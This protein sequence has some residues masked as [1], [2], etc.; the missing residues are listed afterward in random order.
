MTSR[1]EMLERARAGWLVHIEWH[2]SPL[3]VRHE[4][5]AGIYLVMPG[6]RGSIVQVGKQMSGVFVL[7]RESL[8]DKQILA[9][10]EGALLVEIEIDGPWR[11]L[12]LPTEGLMHERVD[13]AVR[14]FLNKDRTLLVTDTSERALTA[15][16]ASYLQTEYPDWHVD[17]EYNRATKPVS[18]KHNEK[19]LAFWLG[20][21]EKFTLAHEIPMSNIF[22][23]IIVHMRE[24]CYNFLVIEVKKRSA[25]DR[26]FEQKKAGDIAKLKAIRTQL[27][28]QYAA[29]LSLSTGEDAGMD[30]LF[31]LGR[32]DDLPGGPLRYVQYREGDCQFFSSGDGPPSV[33]LKVP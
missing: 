17:C 29:F 26:G 27:G 6:T 13:R 2:G 33:T 16:L 5:N 31:W 23:D 15:R 24:S 32:P 30:E 22:P 18:G 25:T 3:V 10:F 11:P 14:H 20:G 28:Y 8:R 9:V 21:I 19:Q 7:C 12:E 4:D 1:T